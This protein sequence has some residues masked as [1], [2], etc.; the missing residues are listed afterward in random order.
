MR[1]LSD[2]GILTG[3]GDQAPR[4]NH[5]KMWSMLTRNLKISLGHQEE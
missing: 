4:I 1:D 2:R 3:E 5:D